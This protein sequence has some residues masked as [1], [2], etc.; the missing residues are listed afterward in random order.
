MK[1]AA[2]TG[3]R[4][5]RPTY[6]R[7][8]RDWY[9]ESSY[10]VLVLLAFER[11]SGTVWD[12]ACGE[13][14]IPKAFLDAD[15]GCAVF[16]SDI[17]DRGWNRTIIHDFLGDDDP[18]DMMLGAHVRDGLIDNIVMNPPYRR[19]KGDDK[20]LAWRFVEKALDTARHKV[21]VL[22]R[23]AWGVEGMGD[24]NRPSRAA[25]L[26]TAPLAR[27]WAFSWRVNIPPGAMLR[28]GTVKRGG[29][30]I[31]YA[32]FVF[33]QGWRGPA[34]LLRFNVAAGPSSIRPAAAAPRPNKILAIAG[35][36]DIAVDRDAP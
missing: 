33:E 16:G 19:Q 30:S 22:H 14:T 23:L 36:S 15:T 34:Q 35:D 11:F 4:T 29:G 20:D 32:W 26:E 8:D 18:A 6:D 2:T 17:V 3:A 5:S 13:G 31:P 28:A 12:P 9:V 7:A 1:P 24:T 21:A 25:W 10:D 27:V